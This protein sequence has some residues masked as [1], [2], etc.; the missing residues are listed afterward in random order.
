[1]PKLT[2]RSLFSLLAAS[3]LGFS[4]GVASR[5][6]RPTPRGKPSGIPFGSRFVDVAKQAGLLEPTTYGSAAAKQYLLETIGCGVAF[7]D[8]DNDGWLDIF[9]LN[10]TTLEGS[11]ATN[12][13]Y[14][15]N[16][17]GT[18]TDVTLKAGLRRTGWA[19]AVCVGDQSS[20]M[21]S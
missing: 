1:M 14:K 20:R 13:L 16:R 5:V 8:F 6:A 17:D 3:R 11:S 2:R 4:Q 10:G 9:L 7:F 21:P 18:F 12:R 19:S 15:N